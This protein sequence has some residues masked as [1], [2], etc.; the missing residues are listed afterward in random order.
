MNTLVWYL[1]G[2][3][4]VLNL[5]N[6]IYQKIRLYFKKRKLR[7]ILAIAANFEFI[8][9]MGDAPLKAIREAENEIILCYQ[10]IIEN[11]NSQDIASYLLK[12]NKLKNY[13]KKNFLLSLFK[14]SFALITAQSL[15]S[16]YLE[17]IKSQRDSKTIDI[18]L[19]INITKYLI[20]ESISRAPDDSRRRDFYS[21]TENL[22]SMLADYSLSDAER[23]LL[24]F[25]LH[26]IRKFIKIPHQLKKKEK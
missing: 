16:L 15:V 13:K 3:I 11:S 25:D 6:F 17:A 7:V 26:E 21:I 23:G 4:L 10:K 8:E 24:T 2:A 19:E 12:L 20:L 1:L 5:I 22:C 14:K 9:A 18:A